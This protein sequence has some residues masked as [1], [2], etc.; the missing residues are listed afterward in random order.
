MASWKVN[1]FGSLVPDGTYTYG[2]PVG[3]K[4]PPGK[5]WSVNLC[6][7]S[8]RE[9]RPPSARNP[10]PISSLIPWISGISNRTSEAEER[11]AFACLWEWRFSG[12]RG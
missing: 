2:P 1:E 9:R 5:F 4:R 7:T 6:S 3:L 8:Q 11:K 10:R 12:R